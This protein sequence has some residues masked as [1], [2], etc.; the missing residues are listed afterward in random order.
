MTKSLALAFAPKIRVNAVCPGPVD[1]RWLAP[2]P[3]MVEA[4]LA[5]TP[6]RRAS[7]PLD[8]AKAIVFLALDADMVTAQELIV[9]G[10]RTL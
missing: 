3:K 10:G 4:A 6:L 2:H 8:I 9:D 5:V 1:T 7:T